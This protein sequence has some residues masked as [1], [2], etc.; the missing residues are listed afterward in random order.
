M[1]KEHITNDQVNSYYREI[2]RAMANS[3]YVPDVIV[4]PLRGG[5]DMGLKF[6]HYFNCPLETV[7][8][9]TRDGEARDTTALEK[10]L[11]QYNKSNILIVDDICDTGKTL[12]EMEAVIDNW[13]FNNA[14]WGDIEQAVILHKDT[15]DYVPTWCART[16]YSDEEHT[17]F[18]FPWE[19]WWAN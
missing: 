2:V 19:D 8:W 12:E 7:M 5:A 4:A 18:V 14:F 15:S 16:I 1:S 10:I 3:K 13:C 9:Q 17:W 6:S 11:C